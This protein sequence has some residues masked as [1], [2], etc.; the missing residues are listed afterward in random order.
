MQRVCSSCDIERGSSLNCTGI[1][2]DCCG[3]PGNGYPQTLQQNERFGVSCCDGDGVA[4]MMSGCAEA[5]NDGWRPSFVGF[6]QRD[7]GVVQQEK[8]LAESDQHRRKDRE[9]LVAGE[10]KEMASLATAH[11][12]GS[13]D[14]AFLIANSG[15]A[16]DRQSHQRTTLSQIP[17]FENA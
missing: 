16:L 6:Q 7:L 10:E 5:E 12:H 8:T 4:S 1:A 11:H 14:C 17:S 3:S 13:T 2:T 9:S 15:R